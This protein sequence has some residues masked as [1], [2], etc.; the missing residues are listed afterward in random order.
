MQCIILSSG[1]SISLSFTWI[2]LKS[3]T[4]LTYLVLGGLTQNDLY[5]TIYMI[6]DIYDLFGFS[7]TRRTRKLQNP[8]NFLHQNLYDTIFNPLTTNAPII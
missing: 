5:D 3:Y 1:V 7:I 8:N 2:E 4:Y 6:Y